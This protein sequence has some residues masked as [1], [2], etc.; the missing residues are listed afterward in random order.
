MMD[1][2]ML[3]AFV[4]LFTVGVLTGLVLANRKPLSSL[5]L[6]SGSLVSWS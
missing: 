2:P 4:F 6:I 5:R 1:M 3:W